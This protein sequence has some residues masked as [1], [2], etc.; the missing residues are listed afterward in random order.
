[1]FFG[2]VFLKGGLL[3]L[4]GLAPFPLSRVAMVDFFLGTGWTMGLG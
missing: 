2:S 1:M 4:E 3:E